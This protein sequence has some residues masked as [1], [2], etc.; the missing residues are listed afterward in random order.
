MQVTKTDNWEAIPAQLRRSEAFLTAFHAHICPNCEKAWTTGVGV[1][2]CPACAA[3]FLTPHTKKM[4]IE[5]GKQTG[6]LRQVS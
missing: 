1:S 4:E 2:R 6:R 5:D 3:L